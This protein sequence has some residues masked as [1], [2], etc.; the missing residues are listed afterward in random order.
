[1]RNPPGRPWLSLFRRPRRAA[2]VAREQA[3]AL[4]LIDEWTLPFLEPPPGN[5]PV[6]VLTSSTDWRLAAWML[7]SWFHFTERAWPLVIHDDGTLSDEAAGTLQKLFPPARI[8]RRKEADA[9]L[10]P[11]LLAFPFCE[12]LRSDDPSALKIFDV[13]HFCSAERFLVFDSDLLF[14][15]YPRELVD[16]ADGPGGTCWFA[17]ADAE[18]SLLTPA[19]VRDELRVEAWSRVDTGISLLHKPALDLDFLDT[20][21]AQTSIL[22]GSL[23]NATRTL[24]MLCAARAGKG[25]LLPGRYEVSRARAAADNA[26]SR[27]YTQEARTH[28][29][30]DGLK[31][32]T[33]H[34]FA[35]E[36]P[37]V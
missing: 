22:H 12:T 10:A 36:E 30:D 25:G 16:W 14:F 20:V 19:E 15:N 37:R 9:A 1:M 6:H 28:F 4:A 23:E 24:T 3:Q 27:H 2:R 18:R 13:G 7:A 32:V 34:L 35:R 8:I 33:P 31:R 17:E 26:I 5:I 11:V 29:F 21:L